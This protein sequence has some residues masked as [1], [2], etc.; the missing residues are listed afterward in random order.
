M[1]FY[2]NLPPHLQEVDIIVAGGGSA[3]CIVAARVSDADPN[4]SVLLVEGGANND[5]NPTITHPAFL[6]ANLAPDSKHS[7]YWKA[8]RSNDLAGR[9]LIVPSGGLLG[10]GSSVNLMVYTRP[11]RSDFDSWK[12]PG[13]SADDMLQCMNKWE[14]YH[15]ADDGHI[16]GSDGPMHVSGDGFRSSRLEDDFIDAAR[17]SGWPEVPDLQTMDA[18]DGVQRAMRYVDPAGR[19]QDTAHQYIHPLIADGRHP[20][21][22]V[23][24]E[25]RVVRV[26]FEDKRAVGVEF[27]P[28][29]QP[30]G[31]NDNPPSTR[32]V[33][34][35]RMVVLSCGALGTPGILERSGVGDAGILTSA[36]VPTIIHSPGVGRN[37]QDHHMMIYSYKST[38]FPEETLDAV[39]SG[40]L[41]VE[42]LVQQ[43]SGILS[44]NG[45]DAS[46]KLRPKDEEVGS[47]GH[48]LQRLWLE[49]FQCHP[50]RP[51]MLASLCGC[52][53]GDHTDLPEGQYFS[54][55]VFSAYPS[56]RGSIH[57][58]GSSLDDPPDFDVGFFSDP[59]GS[60]IQ[61]H[62]WMYKTQ[63]EMARRM[64]CFDGELA[65]THPQ[66]PSGSQAAPST[67]SSTT[68]SAPGSPPELDYS[69]AD[70]QAI[71]D[72]LRKN[73]G[74]TWHS[75]G[76]CK[77]AT[78]DQGGVVDAN[79]NVHG[80]QALKV[81]DLSIPP[82]NIA[83][84]ANS[85]AMAIGEKAALIL[86]N[87]LELGN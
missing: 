24:L 35:K 16:H 70:D 48:S 2:T 86:I 27:Q 23:L 21:L 20:N 61:M 68:P 67:A 17:K 46:C 29:S 15:G 12:T 8:N 39:C 43:N 51:L 13:W 64:R 52:Y 84:N 54:I 75:L 22:H 55:A 82:S 78:P 66:F 40:R 56:S 33:R 63:R 49:E 32:F 26:L 74:T 44:W 19:R 36:G 45:V 14:T 60:D 41:S 9:E 34:A 69:D 81:A 58:T 10:G 6:M 3:G 7:L 73:V 76:T 28:V 77:M 59:E 1:G 30:S 47:L 71:E 38:L 57:I 18:I 37:Y 53:P 50:D 85:A 11:Q 72:W 65:W 42:H 4:L 87:E 31:D 25:S 62:I 5:D 79:L 80:V 83:A